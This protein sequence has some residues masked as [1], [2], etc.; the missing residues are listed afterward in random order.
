MVRTPLVVL[1]IVLQMP[2]TQKRFQRCDRPCPLVTR[3]EQPRRGLWFPPFAENAKD[4]AA[5]VFLAAGE[6]GGLAQPYADTARDAPPVA[7]SRVG[8]CELS[9]HVHSSQ[10]N[11]SVRV[12]PCPCR[13]TCT[14][15][16]RWILPLYYYK[17]LS[18][19]S[20]SRD[21]SL[22]RSLPRSYGADSS[23]SSICSRGLRSHA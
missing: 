20:P 10:R 14:L 17:L 12:T 11:C 19:P 1:S 9:W 22:S 23:A 2:I 5:F 6:I 7:V 16:R 18:A 3:E 15:L 4:G 8:C 13:Q 21:T